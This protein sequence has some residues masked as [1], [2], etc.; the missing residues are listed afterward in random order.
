MQL[1]KNYGNE[2]QRTRDLFTAMWIPDLFMK[3]V[4]ADGQVGALFL[5]HRFFTVCKGGQWGQRVR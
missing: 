3:R 1:R 2:E 5:P 4:E